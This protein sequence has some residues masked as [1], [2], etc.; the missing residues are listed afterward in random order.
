M[1]E[2]K[3]LIFDVDGTLANTEEFHRQAFNKAFSEYNL[4]W[5]WSVE[6]YT[7]LLKVTG[8]QERIRHYIDN[9]LHDVDTQALYKMVPD[10]HQYKNSHYQS[11]AKAKQMPLRRGV[12]RI[13]N[14]AKEKG[15]ILAIATTTSATNV[16]GLINATLG[17]QAMEWFAVIG[18]GNKIPTKKP[19]PDVYEYVLEELGLTAQQCI[20]LEDSQNGVKA[21]TQ[22]GIPTIITLN[23]YTK[24]DNFDG[25]AIIL[26]SFGEPTQPCQKI[27]GDVSVEGYVDIDTIKRI[28]NNAVN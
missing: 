2:L 11:L 12:E 7:K 21:A 22:I 8:G 5:N 24:E 20:A 26:D 23:N 15:M 1:T 28:H 14:E 13:I 27:S 10:L 9:Y 4:D 17:E 18:D 3:A 6:T 19:A 16:S 25:A